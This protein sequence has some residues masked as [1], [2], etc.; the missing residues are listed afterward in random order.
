MGLIFSAV[1]RSCVLK[2]VIVTD[3]GASRRLDYL[4]NVST[5]FF[6]LPGTPQFEYFPSTDFVGYTLL[7]YGYSFPSYLCAA[8]CANNS[9]CVSF[10]ITR[11]GLNFGF[12]C[13]LKALASGR[14]AAAETDSFLVVGTPIYTYTLI[15]NATYFNNTIGAPFSSSNV[16]CALQCSITSGCLGISLRHSGAWNA[17]LC[18]LLGG[19]LTIPIQDDNYDLY[20]DGSASIYPPSGQLVTRSYKT[21]TGKTYINLDP[22]NFV[23]YLTADPEVCKGICDAFP[24]CVGFSFGSLDQACELFPV[25]NAEDVVYGSDYDFYEAEGS[26]GGPKE[27]RFY[28]LMSSYDSPLLVPGNGSLPVFKCASVCDAYP[29]CHGFAYAS[30]QFFSG[31]GCT[32]FGANTNASTLY[33][34]SNL[35]L[36]LFSSYPET[37]PCILGNGYYNLTSGTPIC[38]CLVQFAVYNN[39]TQQCECQRGDI[40]FPPMEGTNVSV[41][42]CLI[43]FLDPANDISNIAALAE[44]S[45]PVGSTPVG[46]NGVATVPSAPSNP[47]DFCWLNSYGRGAGRS[48]YETAICIY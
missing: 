12:G 26:L 15:K 45:D 28:Q 4:S 9:L 36:F 34:S 40:L 20:L 11:S 18:N 21:I 14:V 32:F 43:N 1:D 42:T 33:N 3:G 39:V 10:S 48:H 41:P 19:N 22:G 5:E 38:Q 44:N 25:L 2:D 7:D 31:I 35:D 29:D 8:E 17:G 30:G 6:I 27:Y 13:E 23:F 24:G 46:G 16:D 47:D 37:D